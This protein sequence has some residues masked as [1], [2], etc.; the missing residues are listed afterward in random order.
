[1]LLHFVL[2][3]G[4]LCFSLQ[5][6]LR[7]KSMSMYTARLYFEQ[8]DTIVFV[9]GMG[10]MRYLNVSVQASSA[11]EG[12]KKHLHDDTSYLIKAHAICSNHLFRDHKT[13]TALSIRSQT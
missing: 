6:V 12:V 9:R 11:I 5:D 10:K 4:I 8:R 1:M 3:L 2:I 7:N 13:L